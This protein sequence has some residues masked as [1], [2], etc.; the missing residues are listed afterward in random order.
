MTPSQSPSSGSDSDEEM[1]GQSSRSSELKLSND[2]DEE[3]F[4]E[5]EGYITA[6]EPQPL[7][8]RIATSIA[9]FHNQQA[10]EI[11]AYFRPNYFLA[12]SQHKM[13]GKGAMGCDWKLQPA[14]TPAS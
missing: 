7:I 6:E 11:Y 8:L 10:H 5:C 12:D 4:R 9:V 3:N 13:R 2:E 1:S 14:T